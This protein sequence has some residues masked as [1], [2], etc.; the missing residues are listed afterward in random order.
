MYNVNIVSENDKSNMLARLSRLQSTELYTNGILEICNAFF[1][2][3]T[4]WYQCNRRKTVIFLTCKDGALFQHPT[5]TDCGIRAAIPDGYGNV[6][7][8]YFCYSHPEEDAVHEEECGTTIKLIVTLCK[9]FI[10]FPSVAND[11][12][13]RITSVFDSKTAVTPKQS[14]YDTASKR[15]QFIKEIFNNA[16]FSNWKAKVT[17]I[18]G[19]TSNIYGKYDIIKDEIKSKL[20]T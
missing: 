20:E 19:R 7:P 6:H 17:S 15:E 5:F 9:N 4:S 13:Q 10:K 2:N 11:I 3:D 18:I 8:A 14:N 16:E 1:D 12:I